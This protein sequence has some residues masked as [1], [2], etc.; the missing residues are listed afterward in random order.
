MTDQNATSYAQPRHRNNVAKLP[1]EDLTSKL[2][3]VLGRHSQKLNNL[4]PV[5]AIAVSLKQLTYDQAQEVGAGL[6]QAIE[7]NKDKDSGFD[8][9][10][11]PIKLA[12][13]LTHLV[14]T[15][16]TNVAAAIS[17]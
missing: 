13:V 6:A 7:A 15:W 16:A 1:S 9:S 10:N 3:D 12:P 8:F 14:Q 11:A 17:D 4:S 5:Q 2:E